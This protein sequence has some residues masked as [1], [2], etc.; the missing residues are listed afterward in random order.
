[1]WLKASVASS[2]NCA[3]TKEFKRGIGSLFDPC[4]NATG[5]QPFWRTH[6]EV[7]YCISGFSAII[8]HDFII[9]M[10]SPHNNLIESVL[11]SWEK[12]NTSWTKLFPGLN[13]NKIP[14]YVTARDRKM[15][16]QWFPLHISLAYTVNWFFFS[17]YSMVYT[18]FMCNVS[19]YA[20]K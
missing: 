2:D 3:H 4:V 20:L 8:R 16:S 10:C 9:V 1:M 18:F 6:M 7:S 15:A 14:P 19:E 5:R 11:C 12:G 17:F 13:N